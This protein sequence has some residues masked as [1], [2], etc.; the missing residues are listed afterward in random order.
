PG[1]A[2]PSPTLTRALG[3]KIRRIVI[4]PG[5]G[6]HDTGA[7]GRGGIEEKNVVLDVA[8]RLRELIL[9][10][11]GCDVVMTRSSDKFIPLE[12][13]TAI[14]NAA[15]A[16]L[17]VSIHANSS[18]S[19]AARGIETYY[20][21]FTSDPE[22]LELAARENATSRESVYQL[23]SLV[24]KIAL[25]EKIDESEKFAAT[26]DHQLS[27]QLSRDGHRQPDRGVKKAPFVVLIGANMPSILVEISFLSD[28]R[29]ARL[30]RKASYREQIAKGLYN[31][32]A[33]Y[34]ESLGT[35][36]LAQTGAGRSTQHDPPS[37]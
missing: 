26:I 12:E 25:S 17:F 1:L 3:L 23:Q 10:R 36:R 31:G 11:M 20:L 29:D 22:A 9:K 27:A 19:P 5:H 37:F 34:A 30:L 16:D 15:G 14:A 8:L 18:P 21:N 33:R 6:G 32:I 13:R 28:R 7:I 35:I 2:V 24:K 4:D